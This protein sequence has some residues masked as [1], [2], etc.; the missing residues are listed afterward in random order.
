MNNVSL[1]VIFYVRAKCIRNA[2]ITATF[3]DLF[4]ELTERQWF[5]I[6][7]RSSIDFLRAKQISYLSA[8]WHRP[9]KVEQK[10]LGKSKCSAAFAGAAAQRLPKAC[11]DVA[12]Y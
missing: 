1:P 6:K 2:V 8:F 9:K 3:F 4:K 12:L 10:A 7:N 11:L 5:Q